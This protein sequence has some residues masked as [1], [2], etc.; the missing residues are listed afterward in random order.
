MVRTLNKGNLKRRTW[1]WVERKTVDSPE[2]RQN[3]Q[4]AKSN[5]LVVVPADLVT[6][7]TPRKIAQPRLRVNEFN[8]RGQRNNFHWPLLS[9]C[10][11]SESQ[12]LALLRENRYS[13]PPSLFL[14]LPIL[15]PTTKIA[16]GGHDFDN[17]GREG[18]FI[19]S[20]NFCQSDQSKREREKKRKS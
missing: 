1:P 5:D 16:D 13:L 15:C 7:V 18:I 8:S 4:Y 6:P 12:G 10:S 3:F 14:S 11:S 20:R 2:W 17:E 19:R 9:H